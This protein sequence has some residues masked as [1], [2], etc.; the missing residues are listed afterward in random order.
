MGLTLTANP[1]TVESSIN[2]SAG[3]VGLT[4]LSSLNILATYGNV[5]YQKP[6]T[7]YSQPNLLPNP[8]TP[9]YAQQATA[10]YSLTSFNSFSPGNTTFAGGAHFRFYSNSGVSAGSPVAN[11]QLFAPAPTANWANQTQQGYIL[12]P[13]GFASVTYNTSSDYRLK[14]NITPVENGLDYIMPLRP[15]N[16]IWKGS[17]EPTIGFIAHELEEDLPPEVSM[18][19]VIGTKDATEK[20]FYLFKDGEKVLNAVG[21]PKLIHEPEESQR[22]AMLDDGYTWEF[23]EEKIISQQIGLRPLISPLVASV[24]ELKSLYDEQEQEI[25]ELESRISALK[26]RKQSQ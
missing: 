13:S 26:L 18:G 4:Y 12:Q 6:L 17:G 10:H 8:T 21:D 2:N 23:A 22:Q 3:G 11:P 19:V 14:E 15:R 25:Q 16:Y 20:L 1:G 9:N 24:Q 7:V 5:D